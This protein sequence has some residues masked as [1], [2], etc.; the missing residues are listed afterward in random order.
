M[1]PESAG[2]V[3]RPGPGLTS[4][5]GMSRANSEIEL[6][7]L[8]KQVEDLKDAAAVR[9]RLE[10]ALR[11]AEQLARAA[12][13]D[14]PIPLWR[15]DESGKLIVANEA[16]ARLLGYAS[17]YELQELVSVLGLFADPDQFDCIREATAG[18]LTLEIVAALRRKDGAILQASTRVARKAD[19]PPAYTFVAWEPGD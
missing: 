10:S 9:R 2:P 16:L 7:A 11:D 17:R 3:V 1:E 15:L 14:C 4:F 18:R 13:E 12:V 19:S 6:R 5:T 8:R